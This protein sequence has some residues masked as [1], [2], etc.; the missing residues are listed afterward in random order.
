MDANGMPLPPMQPNV[1]P[2]IPIKAIQ[3]QQNEED[4]PPEDGSVKES[5]SPMI[6]ADKK[7]FVNDTLEAAA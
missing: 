4:P 1:P 2:P 3:Y 5:E 6:K 7:R